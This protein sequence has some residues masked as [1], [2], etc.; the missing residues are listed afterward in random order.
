MQGM[1]STLLVVVDKGLDFMC[2]ENKI[3]NLLTA[4]D[5]NLVEINE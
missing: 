5:M 4:T 3:I 2:M 1:D